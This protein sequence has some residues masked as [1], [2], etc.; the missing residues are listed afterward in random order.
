MLLKIV[1]FDGL[2]PATDPR[3]LSDGK[4]TVA[5]DTKLINGTLRAWNEPKFIMTLEKVGDIAS[6]Y[7]FGQGVVNEDSY[8]LHWLTDVDVVRGPIADDATERTYW[9]G[10]PDYPKMSYS[11]LILTGG[12]NYPEGSHRLGVPKPTPVPSITAGELPAQD[13]V[14]TSR[15]V[16]IVSIEADGATTARVT[17]AEA[18]DFDTD[19]ATKVIVSGATPVQF[20]GIY[21]VTWESPT[22]FTYVVSTPSNP[23]TSLDQQTVA[24]TAISR[25]DFPSK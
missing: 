4:A 1:G 9:T 21:D 11:P 5:L 25:V 19:E 7:R 24:V 17:L 6:I 15:P 3:L 23:A 18:T 22:E 12:T 2:Q 8:W 14:E 10:D 13:A 16:D 20:N